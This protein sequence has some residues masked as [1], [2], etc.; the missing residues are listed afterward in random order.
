LNNENITS[1]ADNG[2]GSAGQQSY[3]IL[4]DTGKIIGADGESIIK[5]VID[6]L[7]NIWTVYPFK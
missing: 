1:V 2:L 5:I 3:K 4:I 6:E 7:G